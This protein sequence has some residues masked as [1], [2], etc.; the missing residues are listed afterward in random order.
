MKDK[1]PT[2]LKV[3]YIRPDKRTGRKECFQVIY[4]DDNGEVHYMEE[5]AEADIYVVKE[6]YRDYTYNKPQELIAH[7]DK[8]RV[9]ISNIR[10]KLSELAGPWGKSIRN[11]ATETND[12]SLLNQLYRWPYAY[13]CDFQPEY[14]YM[15]DWYKKYPLKTPHLTKAFLDIEIDQIDYMVDTSNLGS[16][17]YAP[18]NLV[19][20]FLEETKDAYTFILRPFI[21]SKIG[22]TEEEYESRYTKYE[23]QLQQHKHLMEHQ[24]EFYKDLEDSFEPTYGEINY[25]L[26]EYGKEID[27][28]ADVF[29]LINT[30]KPNFL[31]IWNM[32]FD[33]PYL[34]ARIVALGYD[35]RSIMCSPEIPNPVAKFKED[36]TTFQI[37]KQFD[38]FY[39]TSFTQYLCQ[40]RI[41]ASVR[42]SQHKLRSVALNAIGDMVLRDRKV[43]YPDEANIITFPYTDWPR[44]IKYNIKDVLLQVGIE[45]KTNDLITYYMRS[46]SNLTPYNK[47]F[48]ETHLLRNVREM[49][50]EEEGWVQGNNLNTIG[51]GKSE[52]DKQFYGSDD[53]EEEGSSSF[54]G[55]INADPLM[56]DY[57]GEEVTGSPSNNVFINVVDFDAAAFY[58]SIK[59]SSNMDSSTLEYKAEFNNEEFLSGEYSNRSLNQQYYEK[60]KHGKTRTLDVTGEAI[61]TYVSENILTFGYN[62]LA[63]PSVPEMTEQVIN[64]LCEKY[65]YRR[66]G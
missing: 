36:N 48:R 10:Y 41:F 53:D 51:D 61:N 26:R 37:E 1:H 42:K 52:T 58:P 60:D 16:S 25:H 64:Y 23:H 45:R 7:M 28:I 55:A 33:I 34:L 38:F 20:V 3:T 44:F 62:W 4:A 59:I 21:P 18:V 65:G 39:V 31:L 5:P 63:I 14:Y 24:D 13:G 6:E 30:K 43:E 12:Y 8:I 15:H 19:T 35:P 2:L 32:R 29:R 47:I 50:F 57:V 56:N 9:P 40:M 22:M 46:H 49:Y 11:R 54:K 66:K 17:A 27:L